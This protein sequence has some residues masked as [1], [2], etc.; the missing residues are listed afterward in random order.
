MS[1]TALSFDDWRDAVRTDHRDRIER[2]YVEAESNDPHGIIRQYL[3]Q[4]RDAWYNDPYE[5]ERCIKLAEGQ[6]KQE[7][8]WASERVVRNKQ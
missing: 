6:S 1:A 4:A 7:R 2:L 5:A 3:N 8:E